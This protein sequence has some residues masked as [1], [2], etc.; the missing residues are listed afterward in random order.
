MLR[1][2]DMVYRVVEVDP[3]GDVRHTWKVS[4]AVVKHA[5]D[6][7]IKLK[8]YL[9]GTFRVQYDPSAL[10]RVF[11]ETPSAAIEAFLAHQR[12]EIESLDRRR[13][14]ADRAIAWATAQE[15]QS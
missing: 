8:T 9:S 11:F 10:G 7:Q 13:A 6:K 14:E 12:G 15:E 2:G 3:P 4:S 1:A 5:S